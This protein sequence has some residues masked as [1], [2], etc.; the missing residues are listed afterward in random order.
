MAGRVM[1]LDLRVELRDGTVLGYAEAG[2]PGGQPVVHLH[3][4]PT[5]RL[6]VRHKA[7]HEAA[8][9]LGVRLLAVD[10]PGMGLSSFRRYSVAS[11]PDL[12]RGFADALGLGRFAVTAVSGGGKYA[13]ASA[14]RLPDRVTRVALDSSTC[15]VDVPGVRAA[16]SKKDRRVYAV[17]QRAPWLLR[18]FFA[19]IARDLTRRDVGEVVSE[20]MEAGPAE[21]ELLEREGF[22]DDFLQQVVESFRSGSRGPAYD[23]ILESRPWGLPLGEIQVPFD[24]WFGEADSIVPPEQ[25][26]ILA[27]ELPLAT[28]HPVPGRG[29]FLLATESAQD[30]LRSVIRD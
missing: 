30:I 24:V 20:L 8:D 4:S 29:H 17:G 28:A 11:Y 18:L 25:G 23:Y 1:R 15:S 21:R 12:L 9:R 10:R 6:E 22:R 14:W 3:G 26:R 13:C 5:S 27:R 7:F 2:D 19:K 16:M